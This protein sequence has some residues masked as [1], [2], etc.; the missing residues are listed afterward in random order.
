MIYDLHFRGLRIW[1][2]ISSCTELPPILRLHKVLDSRTQTKVERTL[3]RCTSHK[4]LLQPSTIM[5]GCDSTVLWSKK[6]WTYTGPDMVG[7]II[8]KTE[9]AATKITCVSQDTQVMLSRVPKDVCFAVCFVFNNSITS[10]NEKCESHVS[11]RHDVLGTLKWWLALCGTGDLMS[12]NPTEGLIQPNVW[13][14]HA[15]LQCGMKNVN[16]MWASDRTF[17]AHYKRRLALCGTGNS[18]RTNPA[19]L[20]IQPNV[21][22]VH[23]AQTI[24]Y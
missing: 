20:L 19:N 18:V 24:E 17:L 5:L 11:L 7:F 16:H 3:D 6:Q 12:T 8:H 15:V 14:E 13:Q 21:A 9:E 22:Q 10:R 1:T 4:N 2:G 23:D